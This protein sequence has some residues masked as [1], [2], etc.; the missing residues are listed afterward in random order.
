MIGS[1][2][3]LCKPWKSGLRDLLRQDDHCGF[4]LLAHQ[5]NAKGTAKE[6]DVGGSAAAGS[7][8][9]GG[10]LILR[11]L[12]RSAIIPIKKPVSYTNSLAIFIQINNLYFYIVT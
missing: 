4:W 10:A 1:Q 7:F 11:A 8:A 3:V 2:A 5:M 12:R 6:P 9:P